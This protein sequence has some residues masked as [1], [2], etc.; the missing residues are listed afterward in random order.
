M[1]MGMGGEPQYVYRNKLLQTG[2]C[3]PELTTFAKIWI[4]HENSTYTLKSQGLPSTVYT[5]EEEKCKFAWWCK[6]KPMVLGLNPTF[7]YKVKWWMTW[8]TILSEKVHSKMIKYPANPQ[9]SLS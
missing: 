1:M 7:Q 6:D 4:T 8:D 9:K 3:K 2:L 5:V